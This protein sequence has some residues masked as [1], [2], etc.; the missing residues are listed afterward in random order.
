MEVDF[1]D[2]PPPTRTH[3]KEVVEDTEEV[4]TLKTSI[5]E[6]LQRINNELNI[7]ITTSS[8]EGLVGYPTY[9]S[10]N[11]EC[12]KLPAT[13]FLYFNKERNI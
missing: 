10:G 1:Q 2:C 9:N 12:D 6:W 7:N 5:N 13:L 11:K 3:K 8:N 4:K